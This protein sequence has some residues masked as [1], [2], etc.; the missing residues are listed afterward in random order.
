MQHSTSRGPAKGGIRYH[1][2]VNINEVK[3]LAAWMTFKSAV[4]DIPFGGGNGGIKVDP[5]TLSVHELRRL[6]RRY[7]DVYKRQ[8]KDMGIGAAPRHSQILT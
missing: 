4:V 8:L 6:T 1:Q 7:T 5:S 3:A 2:D